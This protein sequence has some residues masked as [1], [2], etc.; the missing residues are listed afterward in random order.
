[1]RVFVCV[2]GHEFPSMNIDC[3]LIFS[4]GER[5]IAGITWQLSVYVGIR[6][7][8]LVLLGHTLVLVGSCW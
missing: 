8:L 6:C 3:D 5:V 2:R 7:S 4:H 1:M